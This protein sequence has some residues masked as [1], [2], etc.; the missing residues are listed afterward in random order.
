[1]FFFPQS[2]SG[3]PL[4]WTDPATKTLSILGIISYGIQCATPN[5]SVNTR[6]SSY[7]DWIESSTG[8][9]KILPLKK[10]I[11]QKKKKKSSALN[12][13]WQKVKRTRFSVPIVNHFVI[14]AFFYLQANFENKKLIINSN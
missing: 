11:F 10:I 12:N 1:M 3:G 7:L 9:F 8:Q 2:D 6:V 14:I 13:N 4:L 5:P